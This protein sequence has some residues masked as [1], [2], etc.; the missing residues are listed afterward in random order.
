M[1]IKEIKRLLFEWNVVN[2]ASIVPLYRALDFIT[3][4]NNRQ[5]LPNQSRTKAED[6]YI[7]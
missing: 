7:L 4:R 3:S 2:S 1:S 6:T 5:I